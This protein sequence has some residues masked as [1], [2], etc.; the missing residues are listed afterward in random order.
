MRVLPPAPDTDDRE[1]YALVVA[2][3]EEALATLT[4]SEDCEFTLRRVLR[5][6]RRLAQVPPRDLRPVS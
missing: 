3:C 1:A 4:L 2:A 6:A 5:A